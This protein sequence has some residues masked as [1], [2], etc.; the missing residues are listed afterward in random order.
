MDQASGAGGA[1][2]L[3]PLSPSVLSAPYPSPV[4]SPHRIVSS[5]V[6]YRAG[7]G[8]SPL[9]A[10]NT[11]QKSADSKNVPYSICLDISLM[12]LFS[13]EY[14]SEKNI[15]HNTHA[16]QCV[17]VGGSMCPWQRKMALPPVF[18]FP[19][20]KKCHTKI[21]GGWGRKKAG[22]ERRGGWPPA[23]PPLCLLPSQHHVVY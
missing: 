19:F 8:L 1:S 6:G 7:A 11:H 17:C 21:L 10:I 12:C 18:A 4:H 2:G 16:F 5:Q 13:P 20:M 3:P 22:A 14:A 23:P 15:R 9:S